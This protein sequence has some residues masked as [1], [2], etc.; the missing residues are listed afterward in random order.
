MY[1]TTR[2]TPL[3]FCCSLPSTRGSADR[4]QRVYKVKGVR[5]CFDLTRV[6]AEHSHTLQ[7]PTAAQRD[8]RLPTLKDLHR[9]HKHTRARISVT[10]A[11]RCGVIAVVN[12]DDAARLRILL[13]LL[14]LHSPNADPSRRGLRSSPGI[15]ESRERNR[16]PEGSASAPQSLG[17]FG[18]ESLRGPSSGQ[19]RW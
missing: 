4:L 18:P 2:Y 8:I 15:Y 19:R 7:R 10:A 17:R 6:K 16:A 13:L 12:H 5:L 9:A 1:S 11:Y 14:L 3:S